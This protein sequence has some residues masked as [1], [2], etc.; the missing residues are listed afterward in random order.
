MR[1]WSASRSAALATLLLFAL[2]F[3]ALS[4]DLMARVWHERAGFET[5]FDA[6][7]LLYMEALRSL[8]TLLGVAIALLVATRAGTRAAFGGLAF[9]VG[10]ATLAYTKLIGFAGAAGIVQERI[11]VWLRLNGVPPHLPL[12]VFA[13]PEWAYWPALAAFILF[14]ARY[15]RPLT[16]DDILHSGA[17]DRTGAMRSV[18]LAG[19]DIGGLARHWSASAVRRGWLRGRM[20]WPA[21]L[22][23]AATHTATLLV[24][25]WPLVVNLL[26]LAVALGPIAVLIAL[27]RASYDVADERERA[28][29]RWLRNGV[30]AAL[31]LF[32][33]AAVATPLLPGLPVGEVALSLA[34]ALLAACW[35]VAAL[36]APQTARA[37]QGV[38]G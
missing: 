32:V 33:T 20:V 2:V 37:S 30:F 24:W 7:F 31:F 35:L 38:P 23:V 9:G 36:R 13:I 3:V 25:P 11:A 10:F 17:A 28:P 19:A 27:V 14:A 1:Y 4:I 18:T 6:V 8:V 34:P 21:A 12:V 29:L 22:V 26:A 15:P 5:P 16:A